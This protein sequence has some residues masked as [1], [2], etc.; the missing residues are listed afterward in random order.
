MHVYLNIFGRQLPSYGLLITT[1]TL[2]ANL[3]AYLL[4]KKTKRDTND[5][6]IIEGFCLLGALFGAKL[7]YIITA[8]R[9]IQWE[10][11]A[12]PGYLSNLLTGGFVFY[13]GLIGG[14]LAVLLAGKLYKIDAG[15]YIRTLIFLIPF[16]H[17][18]GRVGCFMA[19][20]CYGI[21]Y[22]GFGAV[23]FPEG[24]FAIPGVSLFPVQIVEAACLLSISL[25][26]LINQ[27]IHDNRYSLALYFL[28]Y[29]VVRFVL[30]YFRYDAVRGKFGVF[31]TSQWISVA[32]VAV[33]IMVAGYQRQNKSTV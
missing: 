29:G 8:F 24:S 28:M 32:L 2:L 12:E 19:G 30:E 11:I 27:I 16:I 21:P 15:D 13:G 33:G 25:T 5:F 1:G 20:C 6:V 23:V 7:L 3:V 31:S 4:L 14:I 18:F 17:A 26:I 10:R 9:Y 22:S